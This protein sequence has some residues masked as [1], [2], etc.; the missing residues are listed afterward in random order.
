MCASM[1]KLIMGMRRFRFRLSVHSSLSGVE[2]VTACRH[3]AE[4]R[5]RM[6]QSFKL[7]ARCGMANRHVA[8]ACSPRST[9]EK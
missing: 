1:E 8:H 5:W 2:T 7:Q 3:R 6:W 4:Q 9:P